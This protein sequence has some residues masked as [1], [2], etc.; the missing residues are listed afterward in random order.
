MTG[1]ATAAE[2]YELRNIRVRFNAFA[3]APLPILLLVIFH[4]ATLQ[5]VAMSCHLTCKKRLPSELFTVD[6][7]HVVGRKPVHL[8]ILSGYSP[9]LLLGHFLHEETYTNK[10]F[11]LQRRFPPFQ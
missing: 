2:E 6:Y 8:V 5:I 11:C 10:G 1:T 9:C 4:G 7:W 3:H